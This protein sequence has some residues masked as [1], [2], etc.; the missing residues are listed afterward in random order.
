[1]AVQY[2]QIAFAITLQIANR[3]EIKAATM[4]KWWRFFALASM[5]AL[6]KIQQRGTMVDSDTSIGSGLVAVGPSKYYPSV[7]MKDSDQ[8]TKKGLS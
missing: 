3:L 1:M 2:R 6:L 5:E 7:K 8:G 4:S